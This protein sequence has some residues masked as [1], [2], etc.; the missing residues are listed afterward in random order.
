MTG[1]TLDYCCGCGTGQVGDEGLDGRIIPRQCCRKR[2][3]EG[4]LEAIAQF[5]RHQRVET[6]RAE[7]LAGVEARRRDLEDRTD[8]IP[9]DAIQQL[10]A[11]SE[12]GCSKPPTQLEFLVG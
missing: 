8:G 10:A 1:A 9:D 5:H 2:S 12:P 6:H 7:R 11:L 3:S 4:H